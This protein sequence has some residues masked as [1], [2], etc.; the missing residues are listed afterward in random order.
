MVMYEENKY[1]YWQIFIFSFIVHTY[2]VL[3]FVGTILH[4]IEKYN[5]SG[6]GHVSFACVSPQG[7][8]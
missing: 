1:H 8:Y 3:D 4:Y 7:K 5:I 6:L 2:L